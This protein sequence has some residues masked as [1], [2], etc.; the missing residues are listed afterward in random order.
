MKPSDKPN[1]PLK[2]CRA[3]L[4]DIPEFELP[5]GFS[6]RWYQPGDESHW[7]EIH[8][9]ADRENEITPA[10]FEHQFGTDAVMLAQRQCYLLNEQNRPIGTG[11]AW[12]AEQFDGAPIGRVH[13]VALL[14]EYQGRG[15]SKPLLTSVCRRLR[16]LGHTRAYLSTSSTRGR[17]IRLYMQFGFV[18][19]IRNEDEGKIWE[20][21]LGKTC[22][23]NL[24]RR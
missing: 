7:L 11:T 4:N 17:A 18:P 15:L 3:D 23:K 2:L 22:K 14:P 13:W 19:L 12:F 16:E 1:V 9:Q 10:L 24:Y 6:I 20:E 21:I 8:L 5:S